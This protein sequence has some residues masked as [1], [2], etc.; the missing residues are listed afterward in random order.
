MAL[1][2][3]KIEI[4]IMEQK[5]GHVAETLSA[6]ANSNRLLI[7]CQLFEGEK[8]VKDLVEAVSL[9]QSA[10]SQHLA[11]MRALQL[12]AAR[13]EG[14]QVYYAM[15]SSEVAAIMKTLYRIYCA[16]AV[17]RKSNN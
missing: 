6:L 13:R 3:S 8:S 14:K 11:K 17:A 2:P 16:P 4:D 9:A 15:A 7:L 5:A 1:K 12:V 10:V